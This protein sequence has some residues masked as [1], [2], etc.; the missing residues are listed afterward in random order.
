MKAKS[1]F[2]LMLAVVLIGMVVSPVLADKPVGFDPV[3]GEETAWSNST[4]AKIQ[5]GT[6]LDSAGNPI[7]VGFDEFGY[8][9]QAHLFEGT[10]DSVDRKIDGLYG[11]QSGDFVDDALSMKW[12]DDWL[13][14]VDCNNDQKLDRGLVNGVPSSISSGWLT[15]HVN[16]DYIDANGVEQHYTSFV[17]IGYFGPGNPLWGSYAILEEV[18]NDPAGDYH[19]VTIYS[20]P[21][22]GHFITN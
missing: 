9:Y 16:G 12:S 5:S 3:T 17:K 4:C 11:S 13:S 19:G 10:Y 7:E 22:L 14:N 18:Y 8:N 21:G 2:S 15:N 1:L 20:D 6:I